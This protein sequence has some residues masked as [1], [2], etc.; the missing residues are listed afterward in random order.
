[1]QAARAA[2]VGMMQFRSQYY[3][4]DGEGSRICSALALERYTP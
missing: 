1:M 3:P 4:T 2:D